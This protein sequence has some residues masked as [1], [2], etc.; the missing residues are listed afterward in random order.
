MMEKRRVAAYGDVKH[1]VGYL[2][3]KDVVFFSHKWVGVV[4]AA[5]VLPG[6][7]KR[8][9]EQEEYRE[10][11]FLTAVPSRGSDLRA[12]TAAQVSQVPGRTFFWARTIK[13]PYLDRDETQKL[14]VEV[15]RVVGEATLHQP[16]QPT[17][18]AGG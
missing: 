5:E 13:V 6:P 1:V 2:N 8:E 7:V 9:G 11:K 18:S 12:V 15:R 14:L 10:V 16:M 3:P 4:A 17:G